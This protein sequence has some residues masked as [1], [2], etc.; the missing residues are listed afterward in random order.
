MTRIVLIAALAVEGWAFAVPS[1]PR[2]TEW[3]DCHALGE[4][5]LAPRAWFGH[6]P[7]VESAKAVRPERSPW[8]ISLDSETAW[9]FRWSRR[10]SDRPVGFADPAFDVSEWDVVKVPCSWQTMGIRAS[11]ERFGVPIYV[12][13]PY[14]FTPRFPANVDCPPRVVGNDLPVDWTFGSEDNPVGSYRRDFEIPS[15]WVGERIVL[16]FDGVESFYYLWVNGRYL[17]YAKN[18]RG[19]SEFDV[20]DCVKPGKNTVAVE[21][22]RN[23]DG[24]YLECQDV[25][26]LSGI[27]RSVSLH[28]RPRTH[29]SDVRLVTRP[30]KP[31]SYDG[32]WALELDIGKAGADDVDVAVEVFDVDDGRVPFSGRVSLGR[33]VLRFARPKTWTAETPNLYTLVVT[34][35]QDGRTLEAAGF[36]LGFREVAIWDGG[37]QSNRVFTVNG[38]PVKLKGVNRGETD[39]M[40]GH[41]VP[42]GRIEEDLRLIKAGNFNHT[43]CSHMPQPPYFYH[44]CDRYG[45]YVMDE[46][47][48]ETHGLY[49]GKE[50]LSCRPEWREAHVDRQ[51]AMYCW[52]KNYPCIVYWSLGNEA[53]AGDNFKACYD[54][55]KTTDGTRPV[56][57]ERNNWIG[58]SGACM[59]PDLGLA[60]RLARAEAG[61]ADPVSPDRPIRYPYY[62]LEYAHSFNNNCGNLADFQALMESSDRMMGGSIWDWADQAIWKRMPDGRLVQAWGGCFGEK[63]EEGQG[64][65]DGIVTADR[66][67]DP[68]YYEARHVFQPVSVTYAD[69][70]LRICNKNVFRDLSGYVCRWALLT[71]GLTMASGVLDVEAAPGQRVDV[72]MPEIVR[73]SRDLDDDEL[74]LRVSFALRNG[75]GCLPAGH[76]VAADQIA[77]VPPKTAA[78]LRVGE[79]RAQ[80]VRDDA[81]SLSIA[82]GALVYSFSKASGELVSLARGAVE[83]LKEPVTID[84]YRV[85]VGGE[86][87]CFHT[88][89]FGL[90]RLRDGLRVMRPTLK[91]LSSVQVGSDGALLLTSVVRYRGERR[92]DAVWYSHGDGG[93]IADCGP[94]DADAPGLVATSVWR[95]CGESGL[96]LRTEFVPFGRPTEFARVGWRFVFAAPETDVSYFALGPWDNYSDRATCCFPAVYSVRSTDFGFRYGVNQDTG[97]RGDARWAELTKPGVRIEAANGRLF[98][99]AVSPY[100]P[101]ELMENAH[102]ELNPPPSKTE[103]GLYAKV[104]GLGSGNCG[105][106]PLEKDRIAAGETCVL[107]VNVRQR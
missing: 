30:W 71:N 78:P 19:A 99:F 107:D 35:A 44:L 73:R 57:Y 4:G 3:Q 92:E 61:M 53:G 62:L 20:T 26:R 37:V 101:T 13:Q 60:A 82:N 93:K 58:D 55:L 79:T 83:L 95:F 2:G 8:Q 94:V 50:S 29:L 15:A 5:R 64:I 17:G 63:P 104:R 36:D 18:S 98:S 47:N 33:S 66:R 10:P 67:P 69:G 80:V 16:R 28:R 39:P 100:S 88:N 1:A 6:F 42:D 54:Y 43:R 49:Y 48:L 90:L 86:S 56:Q 25:Y 103:L 11:G 65:M 87:H 91:S 40:Y 41:Y 72:P 22:Y 9:R 89:T 52:N 77:L 97:T 12:N 84:C 51:R 45:I 85:P 68:N 24:S 31:G 21:V 105:P 59:Y 75:E 7:D 81:E 76:V 38:R 106:V 74:A 46:A 70:N 102:P 96:S 34:L 27:S 14:I 32:D 23:S